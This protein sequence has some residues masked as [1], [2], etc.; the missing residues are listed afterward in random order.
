MKN[1][2]LALSSLILMFTLPQA[3]Y[4]GPGNGKG[5]HN[6]NKQSMP[7]ATRGMDR[8]EKRRNEHAKGKGGKRTGNNDG[9]VELSIELKSGGHKG[10][11]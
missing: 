4:A 9:G 11:K 3:S 5:A 10:K 8:A 6:S 1:T 7:G 2:I